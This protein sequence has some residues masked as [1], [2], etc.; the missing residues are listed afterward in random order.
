MMTKYFKIL[1]VAIVA[2]F[3]VSTLS[4]CAPV[5]KLDTS[6][7]AAVIDVRTDAEVATGYLE[8]AAHMDIQGPEFANQLA[9]LDKSADYYIYCRSGNRAG[10]A[11][12][13]MKSVG[14]TGEL[15]NGGSVSEAASQTGLPILT[16]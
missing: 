3:T 6:S 10:Q 1:L 15:V 16:N 7:Y 2:A 12:D 8:G 11:I 9:T 14:F 5:E 13:Y 4:A